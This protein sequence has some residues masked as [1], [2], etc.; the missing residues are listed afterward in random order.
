M[1]KRRAGYIVLWDGVPAL[2]GNG[3]LYRGVT[4]PSYWDMRCVTSGGSVLPS[5]RAARAA[6]AATRAMFPE[7][8]KQDDFRL[9]IVLA[10]SSSE[11]ADT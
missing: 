3:R 8:W 6:I 10:P 1:R 4:V 11:V 7:S 9:S 2:Y 5:L